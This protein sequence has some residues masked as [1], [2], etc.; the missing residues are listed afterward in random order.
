MKFLKPRTFIIF[1]LAGLSGAV[2][3]H[4]SQSVQQAEERLEAM[5]LA[6]QQEEEKIR[7]LRAEWETLNRPERLERLAD[8]FLDMVPP[9]PDQMSGEAEILPETAPVQY[10]REEERAPVLQPV[11]MAPAA[12][13]P[14][15]SQKPVPP[16]KPPAEI[17]K[18]KPKKEKAFNDLLNELGGAQ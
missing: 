8:E 6:K 7:M 15:P 1:A 11:S 4:T 13:V 18:E 2:L 12:D 17:I 3:L 16:A 10:E 5:E 14:V 9:S